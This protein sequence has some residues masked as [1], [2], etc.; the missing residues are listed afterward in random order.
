M[1]NI[2]LNI[3]SSIKVTL[4]GT[5]LHLRVLPPSR[6]LLYHSALIPICEHE[7]GNHK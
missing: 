7:I 2:R 1:L 4:V 3:K 5:K 6:L